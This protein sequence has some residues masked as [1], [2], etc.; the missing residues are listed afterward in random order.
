MSTLVSGHNS[1]SRQILMPASNS[2][3]SNHAHNL[4]N[5]TRFVAVAVPGVV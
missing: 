4:N 2:D 1:N 3:S 5:S